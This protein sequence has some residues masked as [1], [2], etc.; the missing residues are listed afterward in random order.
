MAC[1]Q[2]IH[3]VQYLILAART[4]LPIR[5]TTVRCTEEYFKPFHIL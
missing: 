4:Q 1:I 5:E 2:S 3:V